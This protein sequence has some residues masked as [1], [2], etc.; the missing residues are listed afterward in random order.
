MV[1]SRRVVR[2]I[3]ITRF[4]KQLF[5]H[6]NYCR[7]I[8]RDLEVA[9]LQAG[10]PLAAYYVLTLLSAL[11]DGIGMVLLVALFTGGNDLVTQNIP[12][13]LAR[14]IHMTAGG[15]QLKDILPLLIGIYAINLVTR[16]SLLS[17]DGWVAA[18]LRRR[19]QET[20]FRRYLFGDWA[21]MRGLSVGGAVGSTTQESMI[22]AKYLTS[23]VATGYFLLSAAVV[24]GLAAI[25]SLNIFIAFVVVVFPLA[26]GM[27]VIIARQSR[28]SRRSAELR[29]SFAADI[30]DRFNGLLQIHVEAKPSFHLTEGLRV[31]SELTR[32]EVVIA[33]C[34]AV[35]GSFSLLLPLVC[36]IA[37]ALWLGFAGSR[38]APNMALAASIG[39]LGIRLA[40]QMNGT[41]AS[42][43]NLSR[44]SGSLYPVL[45]ALELPRVRPT[46][47]VPEPV[48]AV[49]LHGVAY[50]YGET[51]VLKDVSLTIEC[52]TPVV[53]V[54]PSGRGK[55]TLANLISGLY[56]PSRGTIVYVGEN[57]HRD[58]VTTQYRARVGY[59][60]QDIYLFQGSLRDNLLSGQS[61]A[62]EVVW[63][64]LEKVGAAEFVRA[65]GGLDAESAE[66][67]RSL[68]GGQ[69]RRLGIARVLLSDSDILIFDEIT[70]GLDQINRQ[71]VLELVALLAE[72]HVMVLISH[73][74]ISLPRQQA[75]VL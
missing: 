52:G 45:A 63:Q 37:L 7:R 23:V 66:A 67:G 20:I 55:T 72:S 74:D 1:V 60:T 65:L 12:D 28:V 49:H 6:L 5:L 50:A 11:F 27:K 43:G 62:D 36:L 61:I 2:G 17:F 46:V 34:Q 71:A 3:F 75:Y 25:T 70:A 56:V 69:R 44:L 8:L 22:V 32:L 47:Q 53:L 39:V 30:T 13:Y 59:V 16:F 15:T 64:V 10:A 24:A 48:S 42:V 38:E 18:W 21:H 73:D 54:G 4:L 40:N 31:Q 51:E 33:Y 58:F 9:P 26:A 68:S 35:L 19:L 29:N 14:I 57:S 41:V